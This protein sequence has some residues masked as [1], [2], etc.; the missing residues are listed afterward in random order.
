MAPSQA[1]SYAEDYE[2]LKPTPKSQRVHE[3]DVVM[4]LSDAGL[5]TEELRPFLEVDDP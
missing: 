2:S 1:P 5:V 3:H 4:L